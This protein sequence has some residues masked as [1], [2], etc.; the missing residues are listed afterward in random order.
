[1]ETI[2]VSVFKSDILQGRVALVTGGGTGIGREIARTLGEHGASIVICSRKTEVIAATR[3][4]FIKQGI[5]CLAVTA[6]I[7]DPALVEAVVQEILERFLRLDIVVNNAAG[8]FPASLDNISYKGFKTIVDID[9]LGTYNVTKASFDAWLKYHGG[10]II[11]ISAPFEHWGV[12]YQAHVAA[13]KAGVDSLTRTCA[14]EWAGLGIRVNSV[15]PGPIGDTEGM[16]RFESSVGKSQAT[17]G[18]QQDMANAVLFLVSDAASFIN[19]VTLRV[20]GGSGI[21]MLKIPLAT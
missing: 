12:A 3:D 1:V 14:V 9:L 15:A 17:A 19:G 18:S 6:D 13:A 7:R 21:D 8:N 11:N 20:D 2:P 16:Q 4:D 5:E 10:C